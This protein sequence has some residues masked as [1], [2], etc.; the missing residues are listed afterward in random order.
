MG[1]L[2]TGF[3]L[4]AV[5]TG[6]AFFVYLSGQEKPALPATT[7]P[8]MS[9]SDS[10]VS[11][12]EGRDPGIAGSRG[13]I[14]SSADEREIQGSAGEPRVLQLQRLIAESR[15]ANEALRSEL[16][17]LETAS[18]REEQP[19]VLP[20]PLPPEFNWLSATEYI[21]P[22][23]QIQREHRDA[24]WAAS[25]EAELQ[26]YFADRPGIVRAFGYPT[27]ECR[28]SMCAVAFSLHGV[29][30]AAA[31]IDRRFTDMVSGFSE[32]E[33]DEQFPETTALYGN[34]QGDVHTI[35]WSL[36]D[37]GRAVGVRRSQGRN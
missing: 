11:D 32:L 8:E 15:A 30:E 36:I 16:Q 18:Y 14:D 13:A 2:A 10:R 27:I 34:R 24:A 35:Y 29:D 22:H 21:N 7:P 20:L 6:M 25:A 26:E 12:S 4:G 37:M 3:V 31:V 1:R 19:I 5:I 33:W 28:T 23:D 9:A 17:A